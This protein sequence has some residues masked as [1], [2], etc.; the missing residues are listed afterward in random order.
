MDGQMKHDQKAREIK[1]VV[2]SFI[3]K[4]PLVL[5]R[6]IWRFSQFYRFCGPINLVTLFRICLSFEAMKTVSFLNDQILTPTC[7]TLPYLSI[8]IKIL[9]PKN[10]VVFYIWIERISSFRPGLFQR[11]RIESFKF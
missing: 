5:K 8:S 7:Q 3:M 4:I 10:E 6:T 9:L 1:Y 11:L 2:M